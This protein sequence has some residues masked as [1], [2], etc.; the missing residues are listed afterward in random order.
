MR[1]R[2]EDAPERA[3][4]REQFRGWLREVLPDGWLEA[5]DNGDDARFDEIRKSWDVGQWQRT[6][7]ASGYGAPLWPKEYGG[8][9]GEPWMQAVVREELGRYQL[10]TA[11]FNILGVGLAGPT[12]IEH[13]TPEQKERYLQKILTA[14]EIWCQLFSEPGSGSDL[15]SLSTRAVRDGDDWVVNGQKVWTSGHFVRSRARRSSTKSSSPTCGSRMRTGS[16]KW[17]TAGGLRAPR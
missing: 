15:A 8:L 16:A 9:S 2:I 12:I 1:W 17:A 4:F 5:V 6:I 10:P 14:E 11:S 3:A 13:G 7:G